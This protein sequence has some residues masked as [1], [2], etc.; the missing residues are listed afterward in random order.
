MANI[1]NIGL[2]IGRDATK[3]KLEINGAIKLGDSSSSADDGTIRY[4]NND[5]W[6]KKNGQ[7][8]S[9][10]LGASSSSGVT[11]VTTT[12]R[13]TNTKTRHIHLHQLW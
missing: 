12:T 5:F 1:N 9:L 2:G 3:E 11:T 7:W 13:A 10:T 4:Y 8:H 6:G